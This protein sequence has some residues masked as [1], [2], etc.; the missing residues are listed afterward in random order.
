[1]NQLDSTTNLRAP[2]LPSRNLFGKYRLVKKLA[3]GG[4]AQIYLASIEGPDG[5]SK[6]CVI[7][8]VLPELANR[9]DFCEMFV[10]EAKVAAL[11]NH[12]N[13]IQIFDFGKITDEYYLAMEYIEG[14]S[15]EELMIRAKRAGDALGPKLA[16]HL[17]M[18]LCDALTYLQ[19]LT[20]PDG[21]PLNL[22]HRDV[23]PGNVLISKTAEVK[24]TDFGVVKTATSHS[25]QAGVV[26]GKFAYM[27]PEQAVGKPLDHRSDIFSLA[28][29]LFEVATGTRMWKRGTPMEMIANWVK[30]EI[31]K[32]SDRVADFPQPL[33]DIL[34]KALKKNPDERYQ[35]AQEMLSDLDAF[36]RTQQ[37]AGGR[38]ELTQTIGRY[39]PEFQR[40]ASFTLP[41]SDARKLALAAANASFK[42]LEVLEESSTEFDAEAISLATQ[43]HDEPVLLERAE[44]SLVE[45]SIEEE[46]LE[47]SRNGF[48]L[49]REVVLTVLVAMLVSALFW[50]FVLA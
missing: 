14:P 27:S 19:E 12:P 46:P 34:M 8:K 48:K 39:F 29:V 38:R 41:A 47:V 45:L 1:L 28:V 18:P 37:W 31:P 2:E 30:S 22:V 23:T 15:L 20:L 4:M 32:P 50:F 10:L 17:G 36:R 16:V 7:K 42:T 24:L 21:E 3:A 44:P 9:S 35:T 25:T 13:I 49:P 26:K 43:I 5:F 6:T 11:F 33:E 40:S